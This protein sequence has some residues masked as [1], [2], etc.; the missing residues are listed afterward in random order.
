MRKREEL[1]NGCMAKATDDEMTFV[2]LGR[3][4]SAPVAIRA[5][6][7]DR[8]RRGKNQPNDEKIIEAKSC[9][10]LMDF[11]RQA[12]KEDYPTG[13]SKMNAAEVMHDQ[14]SHQTELAT[15]KAQAGLGR[16][17]NSK[18][19]T[20]WI[21]VLGELFLEHKP[22]RRPDREKSVGLTF[23][24]LNGVLHTLVAARV[25]NRRN[26]LRIIELKRQLRRRDEKIAELERADK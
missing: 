2:L 9:A 15:W 10:A 3:D 1:V 8:I 18:C 19:V 14:S 26:E 13:I 6:I 22:K 17:A 4:E 25:R 7:D 23:G 5:W 20:S 11:E 21:D 12:A 16:G 24:Q